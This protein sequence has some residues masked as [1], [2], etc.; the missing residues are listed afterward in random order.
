MR[1]SGL[2]IE[3]QG[4]RRRLR[5]CLF[6]DLERIDGVHWSRGDEIGGPSPH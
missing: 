2:T 1:T 3:E 5:E 6:R 4:R